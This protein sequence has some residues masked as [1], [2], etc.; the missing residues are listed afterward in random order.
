MTQD[1][2]KAAD[3]RQRELRKDVLDAWSAVKDCIELNPER[4]KVAS[5]DGRHITLFLEDL[6]ASLDTYMASHITAEFER[7]KADI[8][9][10]NGR[11]VA[12]TKEKTTEREI[13]ER[14]YLQGVTDRSS[15]QGG[16]DGPE[17]EERAHE[18]A[19]DVLRNVLGLGW[20]VGDIRRVPKMPADDGVSFDMG[21]ASPPEAAESDE[22]PSE[23]PPPLPTR[24]YHAQ[25]RQVA[26]QGLRASLEQ[27]KDQ[28][29]VDGA[30]WDRILHGLTLL[31]E[32]VEEEQRELKLIEAKESEE[33]KAWMKK[34]YFA[35]VEDERKAFLKILREEVEVLQRDTKLE[36]EDRAA[37]KARQVYEGEGYP[38]D[39]YRQ[40]SIR[41][42]AQQVHLGIPAGMTL[43]QWYA[44]KALERMPWG[45][46]TPEEVAEHAWQVAAALVERADAFPYPVGGRG[47]P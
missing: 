25:C 6:R 2:W 47:A 32:A 11:E 30:E 20:R 33:K 23:L 29:T 46:E 1:E 22:T 36:R 13:L 12:M 14:A 31:E 15:L 42:M 9:E 7:Q 18:Y 26:L 40:P 27:A 41:E 21:G 5:R 45:G 35:G 37:A 44:G 19:L 17:W 38:G 43:R 34:A 39:R 8:H 16:Y 28:P 4:L 24:E 10:T 3:A